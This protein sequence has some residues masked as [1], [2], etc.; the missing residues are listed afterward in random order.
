MIQRIGLISKG[1][2]ADGRHDAIN[3]RVLETGNEIRL[4]PACQGSHGFS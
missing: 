2:T 3:A 4:N 1:L